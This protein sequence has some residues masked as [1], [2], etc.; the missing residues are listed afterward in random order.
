MRSSLL[1]LVVLATLLGVDT[2]DS[3]P[4][5]ILVLTDDQDVEL[6][7]LEFMPRLHDHVAREGATYSHGYVTTPMC[8]P[9]RSSLLTGLY[10]H[11]HQVFTN[12]ENCSSLSWQ[13]G[14]EKRTFAPYLQSSGYLT[15]YMGKYLNKYDGG[16]IPPGW[17]KWLGLVR[18][19]RYYNYT[20]NNNGHLE[21]HRDDYHRDYLPD[22]ITNTTIDLIHKMRHKSAPFMAVL[23]YPAPHGPEDAAPQYQDL[24]HNVTSHHTPAY[25]LAPNPDKQWILRH[26]EKMLPIHKTFTDVLM[27]KRLQTLQSVD[28]AVERIVKA[29][30]ATG[31]LDNTYIFYT[32]DHGYHLGQFGLVKGKAFPYDFDTHV[33]FFVRGPGI[34]A[35]TVRDQPVLNIDLAPTFLDIAGV[36][37]PP[38]MDGKSILGTFKKQNMKIRSAFLIERGKMSHKRYA[39]VSTLGNDVD[40]AATEDGVSL[41]KRQ[42]YLNRKMEAE[43]RKDKYQLPCLKDQNWVCRRE[44]NGSWKIKQCQ[45]KKEECSC[46]EQSVVLTRRSRSLT[47]PTA[48]EIAA[49]GSVVLDL[50]NQISHLKTKEQPSQSADHLA[51]QDSWFSSK[52]VI[53]KQIQQLRAQLNELKQIRK[54]LRMR[55]PAVGVPVEEVRPRNV[56]EETLSRLKSRCSCPPQERRRVGRSGDR[57]L[58]KLRRMMEKERRRSEESPAEPSRKQDHCMADVK[59]NCFSHDNNHWSTPPVWT[60]GSFCACTNSNNNTYWCVRNINTTHNY[61]YCEYVTGMITYSDLNQDKYQ[62]RNLLYS[63]TDSQL[64]Y[65]HSQLRDLKT[66]SGADSQDPLPSRRRSTRR[67]QTTKKRNIKWRKG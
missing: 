40:N 16:H 47:N 62:L 19:S 60:E 10:V 61:L 13:Q 35:N 55:R 66:F 12:N 43:C 56:V 22:L 11:N 24:F 52:S 57:R 67:R 32:S 65:L 17:T 1:L 6:G 49:L 25:N 20:L 31:Q 64:S 36:T 45:R 37:P 29:L 33:P 23:G 59:M 38:T 34:K 26:T 2:R 53:K 42:K 50:A 9:S 41:T 8:C 4:N 15:A 46:P 54:Y 18:N 28:V 5:I 44:K 7:S 27:T 3:R 14:H 63:L 39:T 51:Q 21:H 58:R 48:E 30:R